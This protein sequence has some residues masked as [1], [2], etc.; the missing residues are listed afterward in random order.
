MPSAWRTRSTRLRWPTLHWLTFRVKVALVAVIA[1]VLLGSVLPALEGHLAVDGGFSAVPAYWSNLAQFLDHNSNG[2]R[3]LLVPAAPFGQYQWGR[4]LDEPL[5]SLARQP[6]AVRDLIPLGSDGAFRLLDAVE[7]TLEEGTGSPGLASYLG[8]AGVK[9]LVVRNDLDLQRARALQPIFLRHTLQHSPGLRLAAT[10]GP[11]VR[12]GYTKD[13]VVPSTE[14]DAR[15]PFRAIEVYEVERPSQLVRSYPVA[16]TKVVSGGPESLL[17][18]ADRGAL[19]SQAVVLAADAH[20]AG[21]P[22]AAETVL[23]DQPRR[24]DVDFGLTTSNQSYTL[25]KHGRA[26]GSKGDPLDRLPFPPQNH[27]SVE[28]ITGVG[29]V[30]ASSYS[31][32]LRREPEYRP[33][34]A[35][36]GDSNTAWVTGS[37][38]GAVGQWIQVDL[39]RPTSAKSIGV[40]LLREFRWR[41]RIAKVNV[42]T[43]AGTLTQTMR[44]TEREQRVRL[45]K[46]RT[47]WVR[48]TVAEARGDTPAQLGAGIREIHIPHVHARST[49]VMQH[50]LPDRRQAPQMIL[51]DRRRADPYDPSRR[52]DEPSLNRQFTTTGTATYTVSGTAVARPEGLQALWSFVRSVAPGVRV[53]ASSTWADLPQ[54]DPA[55]AFDNDP[56]TSWLAGFDDRGPAIDFVW[57]SPRAIDEITIK[58]AAE[59][60]RRP[61]ELRIGSPGGTVRTVDLGRDGT[62]RFPTLITNAIRIRVLHSK[63]N[64]AGRQATGLV[65]PLTIGTSEIRIP[66]LS[67]LEHPHP[68]FA[69]PIKTACG[70][71]PTYDIDGR[72][73]TT[74]LEGTLQDLEYIR[75]MKVTACAAPVSLR[76]GTHVVN[77]KPSGM[78]SGAQVSLTNTAEPSAARGAVATRSTRVTKREQTSGVIRVGPGPKSYVAL[79]Q[80]YNH[81]WEATLHGR[82]LTPVRLDGWQQSWIVPAGAGGDIA[83]TFAPDHAFR[84]ALFGGVL[85]IGLLIGLAIYGGR[86]R[87]SSPVD[88]RAPGVGLP[89]WGAVASAV[90]VGWLLGG[91]L[92]AM[93]PAVLFLL[94]VRRM[95]PWIAGGAFALAGVIAAV[96]PDRLNQQSVGATSAAAQLLAITAISAVI[97]ALA[98]S[99]DQAPLDFVRWRRAESDEMP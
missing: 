84:A 98:S 46:G 81:G 61:T 37:K 44:R 86:R 91:W 89:M 76:P 40:E 12:P 32:V 48:L 97:L 77:V 45:P 15:R 1:V 20:D 2:S 88:E 36:D 78:F 79:G 24:V 96:L 41:P 64:A 49:V 10:F 73:V 38:S 33:F 21:V 85:L 87:A 83:Y 63:P 14:V 13:R 70:G 35:I 19:G 31:S 29:S 7:S 66:A 25:G 27:V 95:L 4:P 58:P 65:T 55:N 57:D 28:S 92:G 3:S 71:G 74:R 54:Y 18:L 50:D 17:Q 72:S 26:V 60:S 75:P 52:D 56:N 42:T 5:Q 94:D 80:S 67:D 69:T 39:L 22:H 47:S 68:N 8:R 23:T 34:A 9:Y 43:A 53:S 93:I 90:A 99:P 59:P 62:A 6:W 82:R 11:T 16:G 30:T 51:L